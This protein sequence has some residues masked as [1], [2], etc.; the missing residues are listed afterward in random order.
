MRSCLD[1]GVPRSAY[2]SDRSRH[3][4]LA[5]DW[6]AWAHHQSI[7]LFT[8]S[9]QPSLQPSPRL[10]PELSPQLS[11]QGNPQHNLELSFEPSLHP[12]N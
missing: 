11:L 3:P 4:H 8:P 9:L 1:A 6:K 12:I 10:N 7:S 5:A 2:C